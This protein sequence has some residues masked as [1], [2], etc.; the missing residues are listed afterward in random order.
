MLSEVYVSNSKIKTVVTNLDCAASIVK[1]RKILG[2]WI[3]AIGGI[4]EA[5]VYGYLDYTATS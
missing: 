1:Y 3:T 2:V 5:V 4:V